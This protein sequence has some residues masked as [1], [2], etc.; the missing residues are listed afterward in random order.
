MFKCNNRPWSGP[1]PC[2]AWVT[3]NRNGAVML[4]ST[5]SKFK[6]QQDCI[7]VGRLGACRGSCYLQKESCNEPGQ[8]QI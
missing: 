5:A 1:K 7:G 6:A 2:H 3:V 4:A 8:G